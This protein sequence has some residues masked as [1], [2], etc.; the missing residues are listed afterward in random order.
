MN[1]FT[2]NVA[3]LVIGD[4]RYVYVRDHNLNADDVE[5]EMGSIIFYEGQANVSVASGK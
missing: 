5:D 3:I 2:R 1:R 4:D